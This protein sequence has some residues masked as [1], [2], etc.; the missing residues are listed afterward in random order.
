[1]KTYSYDEYHINSGVDGIPGKITYTYYE[2]EKGERIRH[3]KMSIICQDTYQAIKP[4]HHTLTY[5]FS[6]K[7]EASG[8]FKD[9]W[10]DGPLTVKQTFSNLND[11]P[12]L[13]I[14]TLVANFSNGV[15]HGS[16][17]YTFVDR[18]ESY[19]FIK[20]NFNNGNLSGPFSFKIHGFSPQN[21]K[22]QYTT[23][24]YFAGNWTISDEEYTKQFSMNGF[25]LSELTE[26][27][28]SFLKKYNYEITPEIMRKEHV[29]VLVKDASSLNDWSDL[30]DFIYRRDLFNLEYIGGDKTLGSPMKKHYAERH[31]DKDIIVKEEDAKNFQM[32]SGYKTIIRYKSKELEDNCLEDM[33]NFIENDAK[34]SRTI[35]LFGYKTQAD[36]LRAR[37]LALQT[38]LKNED[39]QFLIFKDNTDNYFLISDNSSST[40]KVTDQQK[41][42]IRS[43]IPLYEEKLRI[44]QDS[45]DAKAFRFAEQ[46][47]IEIAN[48]WLRSNK[49]DKQ[50][51]PSDYKKE[52]TYRY[53]L[54]LKNTFNSESV[55]DKERTRHFS[56]KGNQITNLS[57]LSGLIIDKILPFFPYKDYEIDS[58][59]STKDTTWITYKITQLTM[60]QEEDGARHYYHSTGV[61]KVW[62]TQV[63][64][65]GEFIDLDLSL[66]TNKAVRI[67]SVYDDIQDLR[68]LIDSTDQVIS[69][70][71]LSS[72]VNPYNSETRRMKD[73][74]EL[75]AY[76]LMDKRN[77]E[78]LNK[79]HQIQQAYLSFIEIEK[80]VSQNDKLILNETDVNQLSDV[81][82]LYSSFKENYKLRPY[83]S[84]DSIY[85][86]T[87]TNHYIGIQN[88]LLR[89]IKIRKEI[90]SL[91]DSIEIY[92]K[93][94]PDIAK[95][96]QDFNKN[97]VL[98]IE[99]DL[100]KSVNRVSESCRMLNFFYKFIKLRETLA[101]KDV[102]IK[103]N[104]QNEDV[105]KS[106]SGF[107]KKNNVSIT[108]DTADSYH[109][110]ISLINIQD[111]C[112]AFQNLRETIAI[113]DNSIVSNNSAKNISKSYSSYIKSADL[114]WTPELN[115]C[116][117]LRK[118]IEIQKQ[119]Q[120]AVN[121]S[122]A[123]ELD[124]K[125]KKLKDK[126]LE[127]VLKELK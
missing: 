22:G 45:A 29:N 100:Q 99:P 40:Y 52:T 56:S 112:L 55:V 85:I 2:N 46:E 5:Y 69:N 64:V 20:I 39:E 14:K 16:W 119:F 72:I 114:T 118:V 117:K 11:K 43:L 110:I 68:D 103:N 78:Q 63:V 105:V 31:I 58:V 98:K 70:I 71:G 73:V 121:A 104:K 32:G 116:D 93:Q 10:L 7:Y 8:T 15:P 75:D 19:D 35:L 9:G 60:V 66:D 81:L 76:N 18:G 87:S 92:N 74:L 59:Y 3:G 54:A 79:L 24:G 123:E 42:T 106:Y 125:I 120:I 127:S 13:S 122:N 109:R 107:M 57:E 97:C 80:K 44:A 82:E 51:I 67:R 34:H 113:Q 49:F 111:T 25:Y 102:Q 36:Y 86:K 95:T 50:E 88:Y 26:D 101:Q 27:D 91:Q 83:I 6:I 21:A 38:L 108:S 1:M 37:L 47:R 89:F 61:P 96:Y 124:L 4:G 41:E 84:N 94:F 53:E 23:D 12:G 30:L 126:S 90:T 62:K 17:S 115:C 28:K 33:K 48:K 65:G 77:T